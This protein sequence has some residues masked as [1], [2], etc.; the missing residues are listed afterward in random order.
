LARAFVFHLS[1]EGVVVVFP[2][3]RC[4]RGRD[5]LFGGEEVDEVVI[6]NGAI[7]DADVA[8]GRIESGGGGVEEGLDFLVGEDTDAVDMDGVATFK[9]F[10]KIVSYIH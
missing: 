1:Q 8:T 6:V 2:D 5:A 9:V 10:Y 7:A 4:G 3:L